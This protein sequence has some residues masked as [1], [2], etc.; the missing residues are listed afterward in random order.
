VIEDLDIVT[1]LPM[2]NPGPLDQQ[3]DLAVLDLITEDRIG[4]PGFGHGASVS[5][6]MTRGSMIE[7][8]VFSANLFFGAGCGGFVRN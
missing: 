1:L 2:M 6:A 7:G 4:L 3:S 8:T 5:D